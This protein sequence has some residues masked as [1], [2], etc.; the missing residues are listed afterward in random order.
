MPDAH[1]PAAE[2]TEAPASSAAEKGLAPVLARNIATQQDRRRRE[3]AESSLQ[4][5]AVDAVTD[6]AGSMTS[7]WLHAR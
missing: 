4:H 5:K 1:P 3:R 6:F 2:T 7:V